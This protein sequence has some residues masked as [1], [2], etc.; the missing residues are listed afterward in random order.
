MKQWDIFLFPFT[1]AGPHPA[2]ILSADEKC[3]G[4]AKMVNALICKSL[5]PSAPALPIEVV[6][7]Q[8]DGL[9]WPTVVRCDVVHYLA[10]QRFGARL[11]CVSIPRRRAI[12]KCLISCFR[13]ATW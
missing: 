8:A 9:E 3:Q 5:R 2:V 1:E 6:L 4:S 11:G 7:D 13:L 10:K 12:A